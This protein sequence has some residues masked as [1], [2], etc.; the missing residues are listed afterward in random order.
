MV[1]AGDLRQTSMTFHGAQGVVSQAWQRNVDLFH[2]AYVAE[3]AEFVAC[4]R[5][6]AAPAATG[7]DA[8]AALAIALAAVRS[9]ERG[10]PVRLEEG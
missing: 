4:V 1:T 10:R 6:G 9:V 3:L 7:D 2:D 5:T 8:R